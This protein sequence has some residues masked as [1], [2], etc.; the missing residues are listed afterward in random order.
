MSAHMASSYRC[1]SVLWL[2]AEERAGPQQP[3]LKRPE[4][5]LPGPSLPHSAHT[6][7]QE[8]LQVGATKEEP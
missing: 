3:E 8:G 1:C 2:A 6:A 4:S 7:A 5:A